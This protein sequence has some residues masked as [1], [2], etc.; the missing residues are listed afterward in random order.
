MS[1]KWFNPIAYGLDKNEEIDYEQMEKLAREHKPKLII[2][3]ASAYSKKIDFE[4]IGKLAKEVGAIFMVT[5]LAWL[6]LVFIQIQYHML[7][8]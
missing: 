8:S 5:M 1:G 7:I 6:L 4:R 3:G 2:A